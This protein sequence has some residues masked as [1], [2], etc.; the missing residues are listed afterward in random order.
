MRRMGQLGTMA[1]TCGSPLGRMVRRMGSMWN[2]WDRQQSRK[3]SH[4]SHHL[5]HGKAA[6]Q[7][8]YSQL[9]H[10]SPFTYMSR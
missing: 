8:H 4:A 7:I 9:F 6:G 2:A 1:L 10:Q 3:L 5:S